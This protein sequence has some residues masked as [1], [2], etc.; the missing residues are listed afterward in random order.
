MN[1][2][3][4]KEEFIKNFGVEKWEQ[5]EML[6]KLIPIQIDLCEYLGIEMLPVVCEDIPDDSRFYIKDQYIALSPKMFKSYTDAIKSLV[7]E[8]RHQFQIKCVLSEECDIDPLL[9]EMW[10]EDFLNMNAPLDVNSSSSVEK[11][12]N[13]VIELDA[14]AFS[15]WYLKEILFI[16]THFPSEEYDKLIDLYIEKNKRNF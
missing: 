4:I 8:S 9:V 5:E 13:Q 15:K 10:R 7:H 3:K 14:H 6:G 2:K 11:Y 1:N 16:E 12:F